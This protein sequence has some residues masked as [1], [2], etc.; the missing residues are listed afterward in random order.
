MYIY[1]DPTYDGSTTFFALPIKG[2][3]E[4]RSGMESLLSLLVSAGRDNTDFTYW[5]EATQTAFW[6][7][8]DD[9]GTKFAQEIVDYCVAAG[10]AQE[11]DPVSVSAALWGFE[12]AEDATA[13]DFF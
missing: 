12:I 10:Y 1:S 2:M 8:L 7:A 4:Y 5:D 3:D 6:T 13:T 9:A 11:S